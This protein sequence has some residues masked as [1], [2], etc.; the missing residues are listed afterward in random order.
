MPGGMLGKILAALGQHHG[1]ADPTLLQWI[2]AALS[3][4]L[5]GTLGFNEL[6][7]VIIIGMVILAIPALI[8]IAYWASRRRAGPP[9][10]PP[11]RPFA[12]PDQLGHTE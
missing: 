4:I 12:S 8:V 7:I 1:E 3:H 11:G 9:G 2:M 5:V 10:P 6:T